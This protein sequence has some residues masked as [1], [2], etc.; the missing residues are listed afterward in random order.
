MLIHQI[1]KKSQ[2][3]E[4][5]LSGVRDA[6]TTAKPVIKQAWNDA[7]NVAKG[8]G[9]MAKGVVSPILAHPISSPTATAMRQVG[10]DNIQ[11]QKS[12]D[13]LAAQGYNVGNVKVGAPLTI[14]QAA[15][16][17]KL[18]PL[19]QF[20]KKID[21]SSA[22]KLA[23]E[24]SSG[25]DIAGGMSKASNTITQEDQRLVSIE[26]KLLKEFDKFDKVS[27]NQILVDKNTK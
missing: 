11:A 25:P 27:N 1:T 15:D 20:M 19:K 12:A 8:V 13:R 21:K 18:N 7:A 5:L 2:V 4:G 26:S 22:E 9:N 14:R 3:D 10:K 23:K 6:I 17:S 16:L 24:F